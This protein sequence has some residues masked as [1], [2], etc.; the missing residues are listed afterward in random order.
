MT[1][2]VLSLTI[3]LLAAIGAACCSPDNNGSGPEGNGGP[4]GEHEGENGAHLSGSDLPPPP[5]PVPY[6]NPW[7]DAVVGEVAAYDTP[8]GNERWRVQAIDETI[9]VERLVFE[10]FA[11]VWIVQ[12]EDRRS[13]ADEGWW[14]R[15]QP[16]EPV[17]QT[18]EI[19]GRTIEAEQIETDDGRVVWV[20]PTVVPL[21]GV[22]QIVSPGGQV[23]RML[24]SLPD[25]SVSPDL[26]E[27]P[28]E[29]GPG[30]GGAD[31]FGFE[32]E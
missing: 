30:E 5:D 20:A 13:L 16:E 28:A 27:P 29:S 2:V 4:G 19:D 17:M 24:T 14:S 15:L 7:L 21:D 26:W 3:G 22:V 10:P 18:F 8:S 1:R 11:A 12:S 32:D 31:D 23:E 25:P 9:V 6:E